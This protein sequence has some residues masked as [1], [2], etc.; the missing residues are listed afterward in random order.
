MIGFLFGIIVVFVSLCLAVCAGL[1]T[2]RF[3]H[4]LQVRYGAQEPPH[5]LMHEAKTRWNDLTWW[6]KLYLLRWLILW[7]SLF[8]LLMIGGSLFVNRRVVMPPELESTPLYAG[9][10]KVLSGGKRYPTRIPFAPFH[11]VLKIGNQIV[12]ASTDSFDK[13]ALTEEGDMVT[14]TYHVDRHGSIYI[15]DWQPA[16][17]KP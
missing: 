10:A 7:L 11:L 12:P 9:Q 13:Y 5:T 17:T 15:E 14:V 8:S 6:Q 2:W 4:W 3:V 16:R 1:V